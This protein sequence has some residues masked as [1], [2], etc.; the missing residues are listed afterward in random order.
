MAAFLAANVVTAD[1]VEEELIDQVLVEKEEQQE[2]EQV[3]VSEVGTEAPTEPKGYNIEDWYAPD[4]TRGSFD[5]ITKPYPIP[6]RTTTYV[7]FVFNL[8]EDVPD[9]F[10]VTLGEVI[11]SQPLHLHHFV[12][13]GCS[14]RFEDSEHGLPNDSEDMY[15]QCNLQLG[16]WAPGS[17]VFGNVDL[18]TGVIL[19]RGMGVE[20]IL[21]NVHYTDG[22]YEDEETETLK[23]A[24]D[25]LRIHYTPDFR[26][27]TSVGRFLIDVGFAPRSLNIPP[28]E[29]RFFLT[30]TCKVNTSCSDA[31]PEM[32]SD[33]VGFMGFGDAAAAAGGNADQE[34]SCQTI[35]PFCFIGGEIGPYIQMFCPATCGF[36]DDLADADGNALP[37][38]R[39]P[40][41]YRI[42]S[43]QYH[44]HLLGTEMYTT[45]LRE[46]EP[47]P[48]TI[49]RDVEAGPA[50]VTTDLESREFWLYDFQENIPFP[51]ETIR[52]DEVM[53][54]YEI[55]PGDKIQA[56]CVYNS[57]YRKENTQFSL[58]TYDEMCITNVHVTF[59]TPA[60]LLNGDISENLGQLDVGM[61]LQL[62][63][64]RC[65]IEE[66]T[67]AYSGTLTTDEDARDIWKDHPI[68][69]VE[70]CTYPVSEFGYGLFSSRCPVVESENDMVDIADM[71]DNVYE[72][73]GDLGSMVEDMA[74][75]GS[76]VEE[77]KDG[78][79]EESEK[80]I[81]VEVQP[82][83]WGMP[84]VEER[85]PLPEEELQRPVSPLSGGRSIG[86][87]ALSFLLVGA[88]VLFL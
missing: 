52:G 27:Y 48:A 74:E 29:E 41:A 42:T 17:N 6:I 56:T 7:D 32:I 3:I 45:L 24:E 21:L 53:R 36:C 70:G 87:G 22:V 26:P 54:G 68:S 30:R 20:A 58:S 73:S 11:N 33:I 18:N 79:L 40:D 38:P 64:F 84:E 46:E 81:E 31:T 39:N 59:E 44:A 83:D 55:K 85:D 77:D 80:E 62:M 57:S 23:L 47:S 66:E 88:T 14:S 63:S 35:A 13:I 37:N 86:A 60:S 76:Q 43:I 8:P 65:D 25:G 69:A 49:Q 10:H 15:R 34:V 75:I 72:E 5:L 16:G 12:L 4:E 51:Y 71:V 61:E 19:G 28:G 82:E 9:L 67:D 1:Q 50:I 2:Q 78:E